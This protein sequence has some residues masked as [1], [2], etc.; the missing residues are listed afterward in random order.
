MELTRVNW[1][2]AN[3]Q[4]LMARLFLVREALTRYVN[5]NAEH[6]GEPSDKITETFIE[7]LE[8]ATR[9]LPAPAALDHLCEAFSLSPFERDVLV[10]CAG[11]EL[12][13]SFAELCAAVQGDSHRSYPTFS[14]ALAA[15]PEAHWS[16]I[17]PTA[18][19]RYWRLVEVG[20]SETLT[21][22]QLRIDERVLHYLAGVSGL[23][24]RLQGLIE[25]LELQASLPPS[26]EKLSQEIARL[27]SQIKNVSS[28]PIINL[29]GDQAAANQAAAAFTC[30]L[31]NVS[32]SLLRA[33]EIPTAVAERDALARLWEREAAL[34]GGALLVDCDEL[35][36]NRTL[37]SFLEGVRGMLFIVSREPVRV[38]RRRILRFDVHKPKPSEQKALWQESLG[39]VE[40]L[41]GQ[42]NLLVSQFS[43]GAQA[44]STISELAIATLEG[45]NLNSPEKETPTDV[46]HVTEGSRSSDSSLL[47]HLWNACRTQARSRLDDLAQRIEPFASWK[48]IVLPESQRRTLRDIAAHVRQ[49][50]KVYETWGFA[51]KGDR[52]LGISALFAGVSGTGKTMAAE[53]LANELNLDLYRI[54]L[55]QVVSKYIGETEKN[56]RRVFD[57][58]EEGGAL[59][60]FDE[61]DALF[62]KRTEV[63]DSH[64]RYA[65]IEVSYL[66]QRMESYRGLAILTT[67]M[68]SVLDTAFLRRIRFIVQFPFPDMAQRAEIWR[69]V[70]PGCTPTEDLDPSKLARLNVAGG[71]I[72]N[73]ALH[74]A[75]LAADASQ[76]VRMVHLLHAA[77][78]EYT[79]LEKPLTDTEIAHWL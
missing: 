6:S 51:A 63:K 66:L 11:V 60:L 70:F 69:R 13:S 33:S 40:E 59:L 21:R 28:W 26:H 62:G 53:V 3:Q 74:A 22:S 64:D 23:D 58:A 37:L 73:I 10:L 17:T 9:D 56:L 67:N 77:R 25:P 39:P 32:L 20:T 36:T 7:V 1:P 45:N 19:L 75:F 42:L 29:V 44:I 30:K 78:G 12:D 72:R 4:Y 27:W 57:A 5:R 43:L 79:K 76:P 47:D 54:D 24:A 49:R 68:R 15:L 8:L 2:E 48:D 41:D 34:G 18:P 65:N 46:E 50:A 38:W 71:N 31:C 61:A 55:S 14:L 52:G 16:A 35:E